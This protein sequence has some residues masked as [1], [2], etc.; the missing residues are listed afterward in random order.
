MTSSHPPPPGLFL[1]RPLLQ[2]TCMRSL[3]HILSLHINYNHKDRLS[4]SQSSLNP[5]T[6][7]SIF[8]LFPK[9]SLRSSL[10]AYPN[11]LF[12][13]VSALGVMFKLFDGKYSQLHILGALR[14]IIRSNPFPPH[15]YIHRHK[16]ALNGPFQTS[17]LNAWLSGEMTFLQQSQH[18]Y[19]YMWGCF[20]LLIFI[21][22]LR[23]ADPLVFCIGADKHNNNKSTAFIFLSVQ[24]V[25]L[26]DAVCYRWPLFSISRYLCQ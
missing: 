22:C 10:D 3:C 2:K 19:A 24:R 8:L 4:P 18:V 9:T 17:Y 25:H 5:S 11:I 6:F 13:F 23:H 20:P 21:S 14:G 1:W 15:T 16:T 7:S 26:F 12:C